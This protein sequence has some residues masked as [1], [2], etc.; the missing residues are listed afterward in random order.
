MV[1]FQDGSASESAL[2]PAHGTPG[3][4][5]DDA[6][7]PRPCVHAGPRLHQH[8]LVGIANRQ[9]EVVELALLAG[10]P[11]TRETA[12]AA[13]RLLTRSLAQASALGPGP[14]EKKIVRLMIAAGAYQ[15]P[16]A[17]GNFPSMLGATIMALSPDLVQT[18]VEAGLDVN[19]LAPWDV[20]VPLDYA[21]TRKRRDIVEILLRYGADFNKVGLGDT[22]TTRHGK[23]KAAWTI[24]CRLGDRGPQ[25]LQHQCRLFVRQHLLHTNPET[26]LIEAVARLAA[27]VTDTMKTYLLTDVPIKPSLSGAPNHGVLAYRRCCLLAE[28]QANVVAAESGLPSHSGAARTCPALW[29]CW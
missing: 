2:T 10:A 9:P 18:A 4:R 6:L 14:R 3:P 21:L 26:N 13:Q 5:A 15:V 16:R 19:S 27:E 12:A 11:L 1:L 29:R 17:W 20:Q 7:A 8:L 25:T 28:Q 22:K 23:R 24:S